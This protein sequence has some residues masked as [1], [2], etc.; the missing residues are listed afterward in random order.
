MAADVSDVILRDGTTLRLRPPRREDQDDLV[1]FFAALSQ[2][3]LYLR[4][5]GFP[6]LGPE[7]VEQLLDPNW[8]ERGALLGTFAE[9]GNEVVVAVANYER[10]R[11]PAVA[12]A[13]FAVADPYQRRGIGTRLVEQLAERAGREGIDRFVAEVLS[14]NRN[15]LGVF[16]GLGFELTR[17]LAGGEIEI[18]FPIAHT[19][20]YEERLDERDHVAVTASLRPFFEPRSVAVVGASRRRGARS[21]ASSSAT[22][23]R[24]TSRAP[25]TP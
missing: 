16:E 13:A 22:S 25:R 3:S 1:E 6:R 21:V 11:D 17:E 15:M 10:L 8:A 23:S 14:D 5:H 18:Q 9:D 7:L 12:E 4:F 2:R 19:E 24:P 20:R